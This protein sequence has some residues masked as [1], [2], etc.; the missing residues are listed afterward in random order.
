MGNVCIK[1]NLGLSN[2]WQ[3]WFEFRKGKKS[4]DELENFTYNLEKNL[5]W[6]CWVLNKGY[7]QHS[8]Y[9]KFIIQDNKRR[10]ISVASV[11][12]R[13]VH[14]LVYDYLV[15]IYDKTFIY[16]AWSCRKNKGL[17]GAIARTEKFLRKYPKSFVWRADIAKFFD[18]V[19]QNILFKIISLRIK[20]NKAL[21]LI[22]EILNSYYFQRES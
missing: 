3:S 10:E 14:R 5:W 20:D 15:E 19:R 4:T 6:L 11:R 21:W 13:V 16:D 9:R 22:K 2:I 7:Y 17:S 18:N 12:D 8:S 1:I